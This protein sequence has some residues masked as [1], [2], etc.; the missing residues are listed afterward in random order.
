M[1]LALLERDTSGVGYALG[2]AVSAK[3]RRDITTSWGILQRWAL[4]TNGTYA[5]YV[6]YVP[7]G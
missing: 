2:D 4:V 7:E 1:S 5:T 3:R 6:T